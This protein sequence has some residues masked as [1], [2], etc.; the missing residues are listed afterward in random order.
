MGKGFAIAGNMIVDVIK[1]IEQFPVR[2]ELVS[3]LD[4]S[5]TLG[6]LV[7]NVLGTLTRLDPDLPI[8]AISLIGEDTE[9]DLIIDA[10]SQFKNV[11][12]SLVQRRGITAFTDVL[13]ETETKARTFLFYPG[14]GGEFDV[15]DV[16]IDKLHCDIFHVG[17]VFLLP[18]LDLPDPEYGTRMARL[19]HRVQQA[20]ILTSLDVVSEVGDRYTKV[21]PP[22]LKYTDFFIV[23]ELESGKTAGIDLRD[24]DGR[25]LI[26]RIPDVLH[27]LKGMGVGRWVVIHAP[28]G[29][30]GLDEN[31]QYIQLPSLQLPSGFIKGTVGAGDA[32][33][34]GTLY[35]AY[36]GES[37][38]RSIQMGI[39]A[40]ACSLSEPGGADGVK[41]IA[42][43]M[44]LYQSMP[45]QTLG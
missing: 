39:A 35:G 15:D 40:A 41:P 24:A 44:Q 37:M 22:A 25:L 30:F 14:S 10:Q 43:V 5:Y 26:E 3:I 11:D 17:Y 33:C 7:N 34:A 29:G 21:V 9:G 20:D 19:L 32:F 2:H 1:M 31:G 42:D 16:P 13:T 4:K 6:G 36:Q 12:L 28:E 18:Q 27:T 38:E 45:K 23:N 8:Q